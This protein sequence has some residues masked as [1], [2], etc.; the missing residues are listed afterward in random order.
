MACSVVG[1][2]A[3]FPVYHIFRAQRKILAVLENRRCEKKVGLP[4]FSEEVDVA[5]C[6][7]DVGMRFS[8]LRK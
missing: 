8:F 5:K 4:L 2:N 7:A 3:S 6:L 1:I